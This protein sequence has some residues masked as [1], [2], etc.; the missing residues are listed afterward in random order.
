MRRAAIAAAAVALF[1]AGTSSAYLLTD[2]SSAAGGLNVHLVFDVL[3]SAERFHDH[4]LLLRVARLRF[5]EP[6]SVGL[7]NTSVD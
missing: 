4:V 1:V 5:V 2:T 3:F 6:G 7:I